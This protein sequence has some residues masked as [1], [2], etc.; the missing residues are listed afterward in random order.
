[1]KK[2]QSLLD[3]EITDK[4]DTAIR[5]SEYDALIIFGAD[6]IRYLTGAMIPTAQVASPHKTAVFLRKGHEPLLLAPAGLRDSFRSMGR[7]RNVQA[8]YPHGPS[9]SGN[10]SP[11]SPRKE[12]LEALVSSLVQDAGLESAKIGVT[13]RR[14]SQKESERFREFLPKAEFLSCDE[15]ITGLRMVKTGAERNLIEKIAYKADHAI[16]GA[17]HHVMVYATRPEKGLS[18]IIRVHGL[19]RGLDMT[20]YES[21]AVGASGEHT[22]TP[23]PEA[24]YFGVGGG[25]VLKEG[26]LVR[27]ELRASLDG[28][29]TDAARPLTMG[30]P[31]K[32]QAEAH[33]GLNAV[34]QELLKALR[35]GVSCSEIAS[36]ITRFCGEHDVELSFDHGFGH[37]IG[38]EPV[39][40]PYLD[41]SDE[42]ALEAGMVL[43]LTPTVFGPEGELVRSYD[44]VVIEE[45]C[46]RLTGTYRDWSTPYE[47]VRSY[48]HGGG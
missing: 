7:I 29:W 13:K 47:A 11:V 1:M 35:P 41:E 10:E 22:A 24:P 33:A 8:Y 28:Y 18:E 37:G 3:T 20:G 46:A 39:E 40:P 23:W 15:W 19:E 34:R 44:T 4:V 17:A 21:L 16:T 30:P 5:D 45:D 43:V 25:K 2:D 26:E 6:H 36:R 9:V 14:V 48:Q 31:S 38:V 32:G 42:T 12:T 27:M